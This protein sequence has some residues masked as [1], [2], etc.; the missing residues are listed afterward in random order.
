MWCGFWRHTF[1][2]WLKLVLQNCIKSI[3]AIIQ[4]VELSIM[5][6][7]SAE[8]FLSRS[9]LRTQWFRFLWSFEH[10]KNCVRTFSN[11]SRA[12]QVCLK[13]VVLAHKVLFGNQQTEGQ[14]LLARCCCTLLMCLALSRVTCYETRSSIHHYCRRLV[15]AQCPST[16]SS[17]ACSW[18]QCYSG[19]A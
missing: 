1:R 14:S 12:F 2:E 17:F 15:G 19:I 3:I 5:P 16:S 8:L 18:Q 6:P 10:V 4:W 11:Q 9:L 13:A 7:Q